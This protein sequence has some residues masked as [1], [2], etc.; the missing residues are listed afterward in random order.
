MPT[1]IYAD[2]YLKAQVTDDRED[3]AAADVAA[4][5]AIAAFSAPWL[6]KL[7]ILRA[8]IIVCLECQAQ[9]DDLFASKLKHYREEWASTLAEARA[10]TTDAS[11]NPLPTL[12][13]TLERC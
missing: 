12:S 4:I 6:E 5:A 13:V 1:L 11:G 10:A 9:P 7:T 3:R 2:A 8:Y